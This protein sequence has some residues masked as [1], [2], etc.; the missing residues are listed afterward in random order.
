[1]HGETNL[2]DLIKDSNIINFTIAFIALYFFLIKFLP[3]SAKQRKAEL[4]QEIAQAEK[5]K[6]EAEEKLAEL[7]REIDKAK[8]ESTRIVNDAKNTA[9]ELKNKTVEAAKS[10][11]AKL[12]ASAEKEIEMQRIIAVEKLKKEI[13]ATVVTETEKSL[14]NRRQEIDTLIKDKVKQDLAQV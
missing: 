5:L 9:E 14:A 6:Q 13:A 10:E 1:M 3:D 7:E 12:N 8:A 11:I 2:F 4:E